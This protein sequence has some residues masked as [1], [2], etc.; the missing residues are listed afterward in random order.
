VA[1]RARRQL[2]GAG[3]ALLESIDA[4]RSAE[5]QAEHTRILD[6]LA[7]ELGATTFQRAF[8]TGHAMTRNEAI[9]WA[10]GRRVGSE[11]R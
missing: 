10:L 5:D 6:A 4:R 9:D 1:T 2:F 3:E 11:P 7:D 8:A